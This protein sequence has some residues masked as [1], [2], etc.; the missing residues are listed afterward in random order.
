MFTHRIDVSNESL[1]DPDSH[2]ITVGG[3]NIHYKQK[4]EGD[5]PLI[6]LHGF[7]ASLFSWQTVLEPLSKWGWTV[8]YDRPAFGLTERPLAK[9]WPGENPY[10]TAGSVE[11]LKGMMDALNIRQA[12]LIAHSAGGTIG[13]AMALKYPERVKALILVAPAVYLYSPLPTW[14]RR[15]LTKKAFRL[16]G[17]V[18]IHPTRSFT[19]RILR[20]VYHDPALV[21][22][23]VVS[24]YEKPFH[25]IHWEAGLWEFSLAP[26]ARDLWKRTEE[27]KMPVMVIAG[28]DDHVIPTRHS[29]RLAEI[30]PGA[31]FVLV[32]DSGHTPHEEKTQE[33]LAAVDRFLSEIK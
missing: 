12:V 5:P 33:F 2:F 17:M 32:K 30:T 28:D 22:K 21:T 1:A 19:R 10:G 8:A 25:V 29:R 16:W 23:E 13:L 9:H 11:M 14:A 31:K 20:N 7:G 6:F 27:L 18:L 4:G 24:G 26:H 15:F 3:I